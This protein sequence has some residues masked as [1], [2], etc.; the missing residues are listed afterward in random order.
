MTASHSTRAPRA[1]SVPSARHGLAVVALVGAFSL[2]TVGSLAPPP[3]SSVAAA[4]PNAQSYRPAGA[5]ELV[6]PERADVLA[7]ARDGYTAT[8]GVQSLAAGGTNYDWAKLVLLKGGFPV[9]DSNVTVMTRWM[10]QE[11]GVNNWWNRNNPLNNG[12]NSGGNSGLGS[13]DSL[14]YAA[15]SAAEALHSVGGYSAIVAGLAA[16]APTEV[17]ESAI[18]ASPWASSHYE[19][20]GHWS[21]APAQIITSPNG[22]WAR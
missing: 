8:A 16:S 22:T 9:T 13:Y 20:G 10:R 7:V 5:Q 3:V 21:Y 18:W 12:W 4:G 1:R 6:V 15:E 2:V 17:I 14:E 19:Y 11:N